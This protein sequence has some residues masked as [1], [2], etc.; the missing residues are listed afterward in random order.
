MT[1][2]LPATSRAR[3]IT[4]ALEGGGA[5][6]AFAWGVLDRL[7]EHPE[8]DIQVVG[9]TSAGA[10]N[11]AMLVQGLK[12]GG[13]KE[14]KRLLESFWQ[15]VAIASG[16]LPGPFAPWLH[17]VS[18]VVDAVRNAGAAL[19]PHGRVGINPLRGILSELL[20]PA[21][22]QA[23]GPPE[24]IVAATRVRTGEARLFRGEELSAD[25][26]L[27]SACLPQLF[28]AIEIDGEAY[29]DG[30][31]TCNPPV[32]HLIEMGAPSDVLI[33]RTAPLERAT[34]PSG[35]TAVKE[36]VNEITFGS[37]LR[38]ELRTLAVA[39]ST[40]AAL[41]DV[42]E[43]L[44]RLRDARL[45]MIGPE[46]AE[47]HSM[48]AGLLHSP[49]WTFLSNMHRL[50]AACADR[51]LIEHG[52]DLGTRSTLDLAPFAGTT[53]GGVARVLAA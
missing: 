32:R 52:D 44:A 10:M 11:G 47:F 45:H 19:N 20:D 3:S 26:L 40:L 49:D 46:S 12:R 33:V 53:G 18:P 31:Y 48:H 16:S 2:S 27:A 6:G 42:P 39:Q 17:L 9:G 43:P 25:A 34:V 13:P 15:R 50:G 24:L 37:A 29:W 35:A 41:T 4:L 51:W 28:P 14:A 1:E 5:L 22:L 23:P 36:R 38:S 21:V 7:L 8:L 30:G